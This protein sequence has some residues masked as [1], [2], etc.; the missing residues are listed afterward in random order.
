MT[1]RGYREARKSG[2][3]AGTG[4]DG[5]WWTTVACT[6]RRMNKDNLSGLA[7]AVSAEQ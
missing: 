1:I 7:A 2:I 5:G 3:P 4:D 6:W